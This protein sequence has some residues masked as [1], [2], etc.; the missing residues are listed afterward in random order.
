MNNYKVLT[1]KKNYNLKAKSPKMCAQQFLK[2]YSKFNNEFSVYNPRTNKAYGFYSRKNLL[3]SGGADITNVYND[4]KKMN[5]QKKTINNGNYIQK[6]INR[7]K[8]YTIVSIGLDKSVEDFKNFG[9]ILVK[10]SKSLSNEEKKKY[11]NLIQDFLKNVIFKLQFVQTEDEFKK[12]SDILKKFDKQTEYI[13]KT[14]DKYYNGSTINNTNNIEKM[15]QK[16]QKKGNLKNKNKNPITNKLSKTTVASKV[17]PGPTVVQAPSGVPIVTQAKMPTKGN[18][19]SIKDIAS[20]MQKKRNLK[21]K[22]KNIINKVLTKKNKVLTKNNINTINTI[23]NGNKEL[24]KNILQKEIKYSSISKDYE[25]L[26]QEFLK[27]NSSKIN[28]FNYNYNGGMIEINQDFINN[29]TTSNN[30]N[31]LRSKLQIFK[32]KEDKEMS[33]ILDNIKL[34]ILFNKST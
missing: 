31:E 14:V 25:S 33:K 19:S 18:L 21:E 22:Y 7:N 20:N 4:V 26:K 1:L 13:K 24:L 32:D 11:Q 12:L 8:A 28:N 23:N 17:V 34:L 9:D 27:L 5:N 6:I 16:I 30:Y 3:Q 15:V 2:K 29:I 10:I